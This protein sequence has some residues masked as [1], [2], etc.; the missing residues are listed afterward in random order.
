MVATTSPPGDAAILALAGT[1]KTSVLAWRVAY[2]LKR[3]GYE[4]K[5]IVAMSY[6]TRAADSLL[7]R[8]TRTVEDKCGAVLGLADMTVGTF[9]SVAFRLLKSVPQYRKFEIVGD[10]ERVLLVRTNFD[11]LGIG[12]ISRLSLAKGSRDEPAFLTRDPHD[13][14]LL[15]Q[16]FDRVREEQLPVDYLPPELRSALQVYED[17]LRREAVFDYTSVLM[18]LLQV[19][20]D[21]GSTEYAALQKRLAEQIRVL[22]L[23]ETQ[24]AS[25]LMWAVCDRLRELGADVVA[26]GDHHQTIYRWRNATPERLVHCVS[27]NN[28]ARRFTLTSNFRSSDAIVDIANAFLA[29][30]LVRGGNGGDPLTMQ[31]ASHHAHEYGDIAV[32]RF[33]NPSEQ[34]RWGARR[35]K[36]M[37]GTPWWDKPDRLP[38]GL[39]QSDMAILCRTRRQMSEIAAAL[40][41]EGLD[42]V[43]TG[44][45][46]LLVPPEAEALATFVDY[47]GGG[48]A[49]WDRTAKRPVTIPVNE[50][51]V[52]AAVRL[53][54][55][56]IHD[57]AIE[58]GMDFARELRTAP[59]WSKPKCLIEVM[60]EWLQAMDVQFTGE[61]GTIEE[62]RWIAIRRVLNAGAS[63]S[64]W[65]FDRPLGER[66]RG[67]ARWLRI[68]APLVYKDEEGDEGLRVK[69]DAVTLTTVHSAKGLEWPL[70]WLPDLEEG[71][72]PLRPRES[73]LWSIVPKATLTLDQRRRFDGSYADKQTDEHRL[74]YVGLTRAARYLIATYAPHPQSRNPHPSPYL[75]FLERHPSVTRDHDLLPRVA[76]T[77]AERLPPKPRPETT[78]LQVTATQLATYWTCP[79]QFLLRVILGFPPPLVE[80]IGFGRGL[81]DAAWEVHGK[82]QA[83]ENLSPAEVKKIASRHFHVPFASEETREALY[84]AAERALHGYVTRHESEAG[85]QIIA[86]EQ[87]VRL[88]LGPVT[89]IGRGDLVVRDA[90]GRTLVE[91]KTAT[92]HDR[93]PEQ[94]V[95]K[96][97]ALALQATTG[98]LPDRVKT[99]TISADEN[100]GKVTKMT[101]DVVEETRNRITKAGLGL[102]ERRFPP[103]PMAGADTCQNCDVRLICGHRRDGKES[104]VS[105]LS[106]TPL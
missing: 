95:A 63:Y 89:V 42:V 68:E 94:L 25:P 45:A 76:S 73:E 96:T 23:D 47:L 3:Y 59:D 99:Q 100:D 35:L 34:Y 11:R 62:V 4:P 56:G 104:A 5:N 86:A 55:F 66:V 2:L 19:I 65:G 81:H 38:R 72:F 17:E 58:S 20:R 53:A 33:Q 40:R 80:S 79:R 102:S 78:A 14:A 51:D 37:L 74:A 71:Q 64:R 97:Y 75:V 90:G 24:D 18:T 93:D 60:E 7:D 41:A 101:P 21:D 16:V 77:G 44:A 10:A 22:L 49:V 57:E 61:G 54:G 32:L 27:E 70:V 39:S 13:I 84:E 12:S 43:V 106:A 30:F 26:V 92:D 8:I 69:P 103:L 50:D 91:L 29:R 46:G 31:H 85:K 82:T 83:G 15:L 67:F 6:S 98:N 48:R 88:D 28:G 1:A 87:E 9:H 52:R 36:T 105:Q